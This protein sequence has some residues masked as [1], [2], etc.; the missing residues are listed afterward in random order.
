MELYVVRKDNALYPEGDESIG[1]LARIP[2]GKTLRCD[3]KQPRNVRHHRL[4]FALCKRIADGIGSDPNNVRDV[5]TI[6][7]GHYSLVKTKRH[8]DLKLPKSISFASMD[9]TQFTEFFERCVK[10]IYEEWGI[11][12][13]AVSDL[14]VPQ[15]QAATE[16][17]EARL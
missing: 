12:P 16:R 7:A 11:D 14:L 2:F 8:G 10:T 1:V 5:L 15:S 13:S 3:I 17:V 4:F 6:A 9:Q